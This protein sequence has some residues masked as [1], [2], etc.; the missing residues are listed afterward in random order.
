MEYMEDNCA[1]HVR[2]VQVLSLI[3]TFVC[4]CCKESIQSFSAITAK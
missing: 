2:E 1:V 3:K 4:L